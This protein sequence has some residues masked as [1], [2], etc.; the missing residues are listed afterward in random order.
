MSKNI[1]VPINKLIIGFGLVFLLGIFFALIN[2]YYTEEYNQ[3]L[4]MIVYII[5]I[6]SL[7]LGA[8]IILLF[9]WKISKIQLKSILKI[10]QKDEATIIKLLIDNNNKIEQNKIVALTGYN[11]VRVSRILTI[12]EQRGIVI[13]KNLGNTNL[14]ILKLK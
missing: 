7:I 11:K 3:T 1:E 12:F 8:V 13:K 5:S 4:P 9:Q 14:V 2:G 10:L 6:A